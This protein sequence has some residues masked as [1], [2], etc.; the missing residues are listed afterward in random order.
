[1]SDNRLR[2][3]SYIPTCNIQEIPI[4]QHSEQSQGEEEEQRHSN[5]RSDDLG[6][7]LVRKNMIHYDRPTSC[8][9]DLF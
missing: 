9:T 7:L 2:L 4:N 1:M 3:P 6:K 5:T 8:T